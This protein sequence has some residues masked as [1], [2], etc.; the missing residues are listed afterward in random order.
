VLVS[1][2]RKVLVAW[3]LV[4]GLAVLA[5]ITLA[6]WKL[7]PL[8]YGDV[9]KASLDARLQAQRNDLCLRSMPLSAVPGGLRASVRTG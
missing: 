5:G 4:A 7:P 2:V 8:L 6:V 3:I 9:T 1:A